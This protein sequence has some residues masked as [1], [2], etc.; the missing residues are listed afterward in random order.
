MI[1]SN[2]QVV[3]FTVIAWESLKKVIRPVGYGISSYMLTTLNTLKEAEELPE[4]YMKSKDELAV[5]R[6]MRRLTRKPRID[7]NHTSLD[8]AS[9]IVQIQSGEVSVSVGKYEIQV[10]R[11]GSM[12][13]E[14]LDRAEFLINPNRLFK[15]VIDILNR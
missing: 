14:S 1:S 15:K 4:L 12:Q 5:W 11:I 7:L 6:T 10:K 2:E 13:L 8:H 9:E 3:T